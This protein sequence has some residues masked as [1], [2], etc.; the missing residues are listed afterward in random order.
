[1]LDRVRLAEVACECY[2]I[3]GSAYERLLKST[4]HNCLRYVI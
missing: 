2:G 1:L 3:V 4:D